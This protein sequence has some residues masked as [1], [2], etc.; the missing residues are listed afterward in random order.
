MANVADVLI[1]GSGPAGLFLSAVLAQQNLSV[2]GLS[3]VDPAA[4]W[5]NTYGIW[6]DELETLGMSEFLEHR[7]RDA[8]AYMGEKKIPLKRDYGLIDREK[9][10]GHWLQQG[11]QYGVSWHRGKAVAV[12]HSAKLSEVTDENG[13]TYLAR[14]VVDTSGHNPALIRRMPALKPV[15]YQAAY[16]IV[17]RFSAP[18]VEPEQM[19]LMDYRDDFL[20]ASEK[21]LPPTFLYAMDLGNDVY[22]VEET[23]LAHV[24]G[25]SMET[26]EQRLHR[27][28]AHRGVRITETHHVERC[29]FPMNMP[30]PDLTQAVVGF[31]G[32]ASMVHPA[33]GYMQGAMLRRGPDL[34]QAIAQTL[35]D[36]SA[37]PSEIAQAAWQQLWPEDRLRKHYLY[38]FGLENLMTFNTVEIQQ[39]FTT[40]FG[41]ERSQWAGFLADTSTLPEI[42]Q[43]MLVLFGRTSNPVR[44][45][46]FSSVFS[47]GNLLRRTITA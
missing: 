10:Q 44:W 30:L 46:L 19:V 8:I 15:A 42:V 35:S 45:G 20:P 31:G 25:L 18:P 9:L 26:L 38:A 34:A 3:P 27:R 12:T 41:L 21:Q 6:A 33:T 11:S 36:P 4:P 17:G 5:P 29:L 43:A 40:F 13:K 23:S 1:I 7:W 16:G 32:S 39:F 22:F 14:L 28:L 24:P 47:H 2:K 37:T